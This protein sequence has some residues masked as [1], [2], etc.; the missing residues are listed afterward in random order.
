MNVYDVLLSS[1]VYLLAGLKRLCAIKMMR[2]IDADNVMSLTRTARLFNLPRLE[3]QCCEF[4]ASNIEKVC[5]TSILSYLTPVE[6]RKGLY[7]LYFEL[8]N[9]IRACLYNVT[10]S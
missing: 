7:D 2:H 5:M 3:D 10:Y 6:Y 8:S 4:V 9:S 1:D